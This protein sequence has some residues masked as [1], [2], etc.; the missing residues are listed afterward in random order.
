MTGTSM[1]YRDTAY[2]KNIHTFFFKSLGRYILSRL[3]V[4]WLAQNKK[5]NLHQL[6]C[7]GRSLTTTKEIIMFNSIQIFSFKFS[8]TI[9]FSSYIA[10]Y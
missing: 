2:L 5:K 10:G 4:N 1:I 3:S 8:L 9:L 6:F 7:E